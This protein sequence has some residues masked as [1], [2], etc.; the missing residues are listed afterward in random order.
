MMD[1]ECAAAI[2]SAMGALTIAVKALRDVA[3]LRRENG[4][5]R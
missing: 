5:K 3:V 2:A 4:R 1:L